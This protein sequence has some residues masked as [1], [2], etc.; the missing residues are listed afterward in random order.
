M[1]NRNNNRKDR[2]HE[3]NTY[4]LLRRM[5]LRRGS[6]KFCKQNDDSF[7]HCRDCQRSSGGPFSSFVIVP[8]GFQLC[9]APHA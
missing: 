7:C 9:K 4:T 3:Q 2:L 8:T 1:P 5:R 6:L